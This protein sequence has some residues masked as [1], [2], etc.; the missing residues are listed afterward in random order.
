MNSRAVCIG[1]ILL[2]TVFGGCLPEAKVTWSPDGKFALVRG[3]DGLRLCDAE[4]KLSPPIAENVRAVAWM[5]DSRQFIAACGKVVTTWESLLAHL[6]NERKERAKALAEEF[7]RQ[8]LAYKGDWDKFSFQARP[9]DI[10]AALMC[11]RD[12]YGKELAPVV[13]KEWAELQGAQHTVFQMQLFEV[14]DGHAKAG[15]VL[16][17][18]L[19]PVAEIRV[20][21]TGKAF[22]YAAPPYPPKNADPAFSLFV[23]SL[24]APD[25]PRCVGSPVS[26]F[27]D[28]APDGQSVVFADAAVPDPNAGSSVCSSMPAIL[29]GTEER[30]VTYNRFRMR[31]RGQQFGLRAGNII[32]C[33]IVN[34][35]GNLAAEANTQ[36]LASVLFFDSLPVRCLRN[37]AIL[38]ACKEAHLPAAGGE[39][40]GRFGLY[41]LDPADPRTVKPVTMPKALE[42]E[43]TRLELL[44]LSPDE[45]KAAIPTNSG[46]VF[47][48]NLASGEATEVPA[49]IEKGRLSTIPVW[50]TNDE[51][52]FVVPEGSTLGT[53]NGTEVVLWSPAGSRCLSKDWPEPATNGFLSRK[54]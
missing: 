25:K 45:T 6:S 41:S 20:A 32:N 2:A 50:R 12:E 24:A 7:R 27:F 17:E 53:P 54:K 10:M 43:G 29:F 37:G 22:A 18:L 36:D 52:C 9:D 14:A 26:I 11:L 48:L 39:A 38:F 5:P 49:Q 16:C 51:L 47:I 33:R 21:P 19:E 40:A 3:G 1:L 23:A 35:D 13:G 28:W 44:Q 34:Q 42:E 4:G 46:K 30:A 31:D 15:K 8:I